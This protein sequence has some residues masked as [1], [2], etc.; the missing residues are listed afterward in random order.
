MVGRDGI[1]GK[2][3]YSDGGL[4]STSKERGT[5]MAEWH[6]SDNLAQFRWGLE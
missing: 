2:L 1:L 6:R 4:V 3:L 5:G